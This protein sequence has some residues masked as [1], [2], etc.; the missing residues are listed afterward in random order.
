MTDSGST[1]MYWRWLDDP[2]NPQY[3]VLDHDTLQKVET[4][5]G[6]AM[7]DPMP[8]EIDS[9]EDTSVKRAL[10]DG[11]FSE[12]TKELS[13]SAEL[14]SLVLPEGLAD[15]ILTRGA[16]G[17][18]VHL[19]VLP[20]PR[21][22]R[23]PWELLPLSDGRRLIEAATIR[24]DAP[25]VVNSNRGRNPLPWAEVRSGRPLYL[26][27]PQHHDG[28][29]HRYSNVISPAAE[30]RLG[31][32]LGLPAHPLTDRAQLG[33]ILRGEETDP[34]AT[35][36]LSLEPGQT[37]SRMLYYGHASSTPNEPGSA[38][39]HLTDPDNTYGN[40]TTVN[41]V[42]RPFTALDLLLGTSDVYTRDDG[43]LYP[44]PENLPGHEIWPM[45]PRVAL[46]ACESGADHRA[47]ET[48]GLVMALLNAGAE[49]VTTTRWTLATD[50]ALQFINGIDGLPTTDLVLTVDK[51]HETDDPVTAI[52]QWQLGELQSWNSGA[53]VQHTPLIWAALTTHVAPEQAPLTAEEL[54]AVLQP[55]GQAEDVP[56][57]RQS[58]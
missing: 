43:T 9:P 29:H 12:P 26:L 39:I 10:L 38:A 19:R 6:A 51:A 16:A 53:G 24:L 46:I 31:P 18:T 8:D 11:P 57:A 1:Y 45:P 44:H 42:H 2:D 55:V 4:L 23:V 7:V 33:R 32:A 17:Q 27:E 58:T 49:I 40:A 48:F 22:A 3:K 47:L 21:L 25:A 56:E 20:S 30:E 41:G 54:Q 14:A 28:A 35:A 37:P 15:D 36:I 50:Y 52:R 13:W 34:D 5:I